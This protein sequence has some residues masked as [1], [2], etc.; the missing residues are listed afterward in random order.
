MKIQFHYEENAGFF[1][2]Q[3]SCKIPVGP[4]VP[5]CWIDG[6]KWLTTFLM[7]QKQSNILDGIPYQMS[8][9]FVQDHLGFNDGVLGWGGYVTAHSSNNQSHLPTISGI[10]MDPPI[11]GL[12]YGTVSFPYYSHI[13]RDSYGSGMGNLPQRSPIIGGPWK[14]LEFSHQ[15]GDLE[16]WCVDRILIGHPPKKKKTK[17]RIKKLGYGCFQ[18]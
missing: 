14:S 3:Q 10:F 13:F 15:A 7:I 9:G 1:P 5:T 18:K 4:I 8:K 6:R 11:M 2:Y 12:L 17:G 16:T